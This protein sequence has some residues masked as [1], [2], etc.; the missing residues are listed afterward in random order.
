MV[1]VDSASIPGIMDQPDYVKDYPKQLADRQK[2]NE[3]RIVSV[4]IPIWNKAG[5]KAFVTVNAQDN[6]DRWIMELN[7]QTGALTLLD[8]QRDEAWIGGPGIPSYNYGGGTLGFL[9][10]NETIYYQSEASGFSHL[11][12]LN[13]N[14]K[15]LIS[16]KPPKYHYKQYI[17]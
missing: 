2:K 4:G 5:T 10:D 8:R 9:K 15:T 7:P 14:S 12:T 17:C 3:D 16:F 13:L 1:A 6:K 11:Y